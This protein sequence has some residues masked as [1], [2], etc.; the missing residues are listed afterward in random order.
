[1]NTEKIELAHGYTATIANDTDPQNPF[2]DWDC[3]PPIAVMNLDRHSG[4]I[5]NY[6]G[7]TLDLPTLLDL[8][9]A[10]K[11]ESRT[12]KREI[13]AALPFTMADL[14]EEIR[15]MGN[16]RDAIDNLVGNLSPYGWGEWNEYFDA[17]KAVAAVAG[18][19]CHLTQSNGYSQGDCALVFTAA[20][21]SWI[22]RVG[23]PEDTHARQCEAACDLWAAWAWGDV[24][25]VQSIEA[26]ADGEEI[27][28]GACW[29][30]YGSDHKQSGLLDHCRQFV[31]WHITHRAKEAAKQREYEAREAVE[32]HAAA[33]R[34]IITA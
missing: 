18:I 7:D 14:R 19:P 25:G 21:P 27:E 1:M 5:E 30:F 29:G 6:K 15:D 31:E 2:E 11:W 32:S 4:S 26:P 23:A 24:Y 3:E 13:L 20:L 28:D 8:I 17:M 16:F 12:G 10:E 22:A 9:S 34:D 33:C